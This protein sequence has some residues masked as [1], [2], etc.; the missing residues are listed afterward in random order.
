MLQNSN[1]LRRSQ[2]LPTYSTFDSLPNIAEIFVAYFYNLQKYLVF[3]SGNF[4]E[5]RNLS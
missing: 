2:P 4:V 5:C 3:C 1:F